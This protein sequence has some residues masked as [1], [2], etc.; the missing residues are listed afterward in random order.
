MDTNFLS[1]ILGSFIGFVAT[2]ASAQIVSFYNRRSQEKSFKVSMRLELAETVK[3]LDDIRSSQDKQSFYDYILLTVLDRSVENL[4]EQ[5][6]SV[7]VIRDEATQKMA[8]RVIGKL[9]VL[10]ADMRGTQDYDYA[11]TT[12]SDSVS[13]ESKAKLIEK[14]R[15]NQA[16][17]TIEVKRDINELDQLLMSKK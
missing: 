17:D 14:K 13:P 7:H 12:K 6:K 16:L 4:Q 15:G 10:A 11:D 5:R 3:T 1:A 2:L 8:Y 9:S